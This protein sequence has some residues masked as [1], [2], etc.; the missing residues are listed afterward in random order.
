MLGYPCLIMHNTPMLLYR[1]ILA[2]C[3]LQLDFPFYSDSNTVFSHFEA[4][5]SNLTHVC[6]YQH[7]T[8]KSC[9]LSMKK[10][11]SL[12]QSSEHKLDPCIKSTG[13]SSYNRNQRCTFSFRQHNTTKPPNMPL[14]FINTEDIAILCMSASLFLLVHC[15]V[16]SEQKS[17]SIW[18]S[19]LIKTH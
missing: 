2:W 17:C 9:I 1:M 12:S 13:A 7:F 8:V 6:K 5:L 14:V 19:M 18:L 16:T 3:K 4:H 10:K 15:L 11:K